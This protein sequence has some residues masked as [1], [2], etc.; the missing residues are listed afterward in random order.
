V[1]EQPAG[2]KVVLSFGRFALCPAERWLTEDGVPL[3]LGARALDTLIA[4]ASRPNEVIGK[5]DLIAAV[6]PDV[7]V[8]EGSLRFHIAGLRKALGHGKDGARYIATLAGRGYCFVAPVTRTAS[9]VGG[10]VATEAEVSRATF[11]PARLARMVGRE[12]DIAGIS[13]ELLA[14]RFVTIVG[15]GG[16]GKTTV[17]VAVAHDLLTAFDGAVLFIDLGVLSD[18]R[19]VPASVASM[20]GLSVQSDDP[21]PSL[22]AFLGLRRAL[23][24]LDT[25]EH[26]IDDA[27]RF[28]ARVFTASPGLH[29]L[30]TSREALRVEGERVRRL[31]PLGCPPDGASLSVDDILTF[32]AARLFVERARASGAR[33][34]LA[35]ANAA[36]VGSICRKL[37]GMALA[38]E[39]AAGRV[40][41]HGLDRIATLLDQRFT[42]LWPGQRTA[43]ARQK[44]LRATLEWSYGLLSD[45]ERL[46]FRHLAAFVGSFTLDAALAVVAHEP[47]DAAWV[48]AAIDSLVDKS[49][50]MA[51][52]G[53]TSVPGATMRYRL[54]DTA[55]AYAQ[56]IGGDRTER[57]ALARR[58]AAY[59]LGWLEQ[60]AAL[61]GALLD[62][63]RR[64]AHL[65]ELN[66]VRAALAWCFGDDGDAGFGIVL[67]AA[68][69]PVLF[70][71]SLLPEC[72]LWSRRA[73]AALDET[74]IGGHREMR[75]QA[76]L[77]LASMWTSGNSEATF[78][79][80]HRSM[81][82][83]S[84]RGDALT[85]MV[86]LA[87]LHV[88]HLLSGD[89][90]KAMHFARQVAALSRTVEDP[91]AIALSR[92]LLGYSHHFAGELNDA[93]RE[94][95][96]AL[97]PDPGARQ[98]QESADSLPVTIKGDA[99]A[100]PILALASSA[101]ADALART[102]WMQG[103]P[104]AAMDYIDKTLNDTASTSHPVT[105]LVG[106]LY[107]ISVLIWNGDLDEADRQIDRFIAHAETYASTSHVILGR[108]FKG[109]VAISRGD[110]GNGLELL[111][112]S[113]SDLRARRYELL[114]T[115]FNIS[116]VRALAATGRY[117]EGI[118]LVETATRSV[119]TNGDACHMPELLRVK[120]E[121]LLSLPEPPEDAADACLWES[122]ALSRS[123]GALAWELRT[124][125]DLA[126]RLAAQDGARRAEALLR[127]VVDRF[128]AGSRTADLTMARRLLADWIDTDQR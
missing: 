6:W 32:P 89:F 17:A 127:P 63:A 100:A 42:L 43:P 24:V 28:A 114:T 64:A 54:L 13:A 108:C 84:E 40:E 71:M 106:L 77:G 82:I 68:A 70:A 88:F 111:R 15:P 110:S 34:D 101:A 25:C 60:F 11:L 23:L 50:I 79:A 94:F 80:L 20:L 90:S 45:A 38:I 87:P 37:D 95:E 76:A 61:G 41:T 47:A 1:S 5:R 125:I 112:S 49:M 115:S 55:R 116:L 75:L 56:E 104:A 7:I 73:I 14:S 3:E 107:A 92:I 113:L 58:H 78:A 105:L 85:Q 69:A 9:P 10:P 67:A 46:V 122:V 126:R 52:P 53:T 83:A 4:L 16:V 12:D 103:H 124:T 22:V 93:R 31:S 27:A 65:V 97:V 2:A 91:D 98:F 39:L 19:M 118:A 121:L 66:D 96:A 21:V 57:R 30:A 119:E 81:A 51:S 109:Q 117:D 26:V 128:A 123:Q 102:L 8:E 120:A 86:L 99:M 18:P 72:Q 59:C 62:P 48:F 74:M 35:N 33:L 36:I 29:I 44:T